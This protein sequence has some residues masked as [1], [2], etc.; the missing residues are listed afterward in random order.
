M[1]VVINL[2]KN[3]FCVTFAMNLNLLIMARPIKETPVLKGKDAIRFWEAAENVVPA[4]E[5]EKKRISLAY[6]EFQKIA[7]FPL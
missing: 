5:K 6:E 4:S 1:C 7:D 2:F 3:S